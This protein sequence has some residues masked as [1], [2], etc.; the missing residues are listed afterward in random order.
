M[1]SLLNIQIIFLFLV[2]LLM[3]LTQPNK[4]RKSAKSKNTQKINPEI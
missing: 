2:S 4:L 1:S 3:K